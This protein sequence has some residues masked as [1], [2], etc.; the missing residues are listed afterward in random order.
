MSNKWVLLTAGL[1]GASFEAAARRVISQ[2]E[3]LFGWQRRIALTSQNLREYCPS[4]SSRYS[5]ILTPHTV[6]FG[7]MAW[8]AEIVFRTLRNDFGP[9]DGVVW[10]DAGCEVVSN[11]LSRLILKH[12]MRAARQV[13]A[14]VFTL[15]TPEMAY[16]KR[17]LF[18]EFPDI[19][20]NDRSPQI[21]TTNFYLY[22]VDGLEI[23]KRWFEIS[24]KSEAMIDESPSKLGESREFVIHRHDQSIFSLCCKTKSH[25]RKFKTLT[26]GSNTKSASFR[27]FG[28]PFWAA[29]NRT[30]V[31]QVPNWYNF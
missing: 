26:T 24:I 27:G 17:D 11:P 3:S 25:F 21:Q 16:T 28:S 19:P 15:D 7:Y 1:G 29:R 23:A 13:G 9:C 18:E 6:G 14:A 30:G 22:G 12:H 31:S 5:H 20:S 4:C 10:V 8:K 2:S